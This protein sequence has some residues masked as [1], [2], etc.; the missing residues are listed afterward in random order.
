[1]YNATTSDG[2]NTGT[3][4]LNLGTGTSFAAPH[5]ERGG[6]WP[7]VREKLAACLDYPAWDERI[8]G[9]SLIL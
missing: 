4:K 9:Y 6:C 8:L 3:A 5:G 7:K 2:T 1:M